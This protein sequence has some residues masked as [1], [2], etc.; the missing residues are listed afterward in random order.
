MALKFLLTTA[1][2]GDLDESIQSEYKA[3]AADSDHD[4]ELDVDG[5]VP[6]LKTANAAVKEFRANNIRYKQERDTFK[7]ERD[8]LQTALD[9][10]K[11]QGG[12][13]GDGS[14][15]RL[16]KLEKDLKREREAREA[17]ENQSSEQ[18]FNSIVRR[19]AKVAQVSDAALDD[20]TAHLRHRR[21]MALQD[22][23]KVLSKDGTT[24]EEALTAMRKD[25]PF[26]FAESEGGGTPP[27]GPGRKP[28]VT[29]PTEVPRGEFLANEDKIISGEAVG[30]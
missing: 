22:D 7:G 15:A 28:G 25:V 6:G 9:E 29:P 4:F 14:A 16:A 24:L 30:K 23:G 1:E 11:E 20:A 2:Y 26:F 3:A 8:T 13:G 5:D 12:G 27:G 19:A 10:A 17:A 18:R 21:S